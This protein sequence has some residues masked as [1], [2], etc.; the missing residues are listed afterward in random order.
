[1]RTIREMLGNDEKV[2]LLPI[3]RGIIN[4]SGSS[5][6]ALILPCFGLWSRGL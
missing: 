1:M 3:S 6:Y 4:I 2:L 5:R